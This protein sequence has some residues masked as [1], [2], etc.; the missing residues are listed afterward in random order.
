MYA[1]EGEK[2]VVVAVQ[3]SARVLRLKKGKQE[4]L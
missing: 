3:L 2:V 1:K 4:T